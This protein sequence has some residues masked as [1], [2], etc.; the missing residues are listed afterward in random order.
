MRQVRILG[1]LT[2]TAFAVLSGCTQPS[3]AGLAERPRSKPATLPVRLEGPTEDT[4]ILGGVS[5]ASGELLILENDG[6]VSRTPVDSAEGRRSLR[7][8]EEE[9]RGLSE[10]LVEDTS[11]NVADLP[12]PPTAQEIAMEEFAARRQP[13]NL[14]ANLTAAPEE[15]FLYGTVRPV[16]REEG[17]SADM[18][19]VLVNTDE[20]LDDATAFAYA[21]CTLAAWS[22]DT[23]TP[24]ARHIRTISK[25]RGGVLA[26]DSI[27][28][29]SRSLPLGL[30]IME[31]EEI[32]QQCR[33]NGIPARVTVGPVEGT[34]ENG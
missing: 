25:R 4:S 1:G 31:Q 17:G 2:V 21:A 14:P 20:G 33:A 11:I 26:L 9:M 12:K 30:Q 7:Q 16:S 13:L 18:F 29:M 32:L 22:R 28:V 24:Y 27:F 34:E 23:G 15:A 5:T 8:S 10:F 6:T 19:S 3:D